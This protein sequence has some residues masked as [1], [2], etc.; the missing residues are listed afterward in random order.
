MASKKA[1]SLRRHRASVLDTLMMPILGEIPPDEDLA[2]GRSLEQTLLERSV[3]VAFM[4]L[5]TGFMLT[6][7]IISFLIARLI[8]VS[9]FKLILRSVDVLL[10]RVTCSSIR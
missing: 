10:E 4:A 1:R 7:P 2:L 6:D 9:A 8:L 3:L 5:T